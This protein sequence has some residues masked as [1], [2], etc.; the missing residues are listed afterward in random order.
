MFK[1]KPS[2]QIFII[3]E[4]GVNHNG[5]LRCAKKLIDAAAAAG[6]DAVK[7]QTFIVESLVTSDAPQASYQKKNAA[8]TSQRAM[9]KKLELSFPAFRKLAAYSRR[10]GIIFLSTPFDSESARFLDGLKVPLFKISSGDLNN[11]PFLVEIASYRRPMIISTGMATLTEI[12]E[13]VRA[14]RKTG[15]RKLTLLQCTTNYPTDYRDVNLR[16]MAALREK[17][18]LPVGLSDHTQGIEVAVA[19][20][21]LGAT[22]VEKHF[23]LDKSMPGPDHKASLDP[24][25]LAAMVRAI[26]NVEMAMGDGKKSVRCCEKEVRAVARKSLVAACEIPAGIRITARD[27]VIK[28]PGT[29]IAPADIRWVIGRKTACGI[30]RDRVLRWVDLV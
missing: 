3:A 9:L 18:D 1:S 26:R 15:N 27:L 13:A 24:V 29:G 17:F 28:R 30:R 23:T 11:I 8:D 22:V 20:A 12:G 21:A 19:A 7:F 16:A 10:R 25:E 4:A 14:I 5:D 6:I 2:R